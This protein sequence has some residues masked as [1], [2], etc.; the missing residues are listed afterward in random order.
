MKD[1]ATEEMLVDSKKMKIGN[2]Q[3]SLN[4]FAGAT[5]T[6]EDILDLLENF[7]IIFRQS[8]WINEKFYI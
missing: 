5:A 3:L 2:R 8:I 7:G 6:T 4:D 1:P